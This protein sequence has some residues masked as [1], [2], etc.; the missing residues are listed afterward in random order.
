MDGAFQVTD[1]EAVEMTYHLLR[2][3]GIFVGPSAALNVCGAV[4]LA[5]KMGTGMNIVTILCDTGSNYNSKVFNQAWLKEK[6]LEPEVTGNNVDFI[7]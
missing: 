1:R 3:D 4:K 6:G 5:R 7:G 2:N